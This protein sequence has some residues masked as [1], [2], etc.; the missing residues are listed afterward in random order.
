LTR[1]S[2]I[3]IRLSEN[4]LEINLAEVIILASLRKLD[5]KKLDYKKVENIAVSGE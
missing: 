5:Y 2:A 1:K 4:A 3:N